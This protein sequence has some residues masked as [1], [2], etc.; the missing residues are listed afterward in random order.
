MTITKTSRY[1]LNLIK[2]PIITDKTSKYIED[3]RYCFCVDRKANK[4]LIKEAIEYMFDVKVQK[5]NTLIQ[6]TKKKRI[7]K[8]Q[9]YKARYKKAIIKL[10][11]G[12]QINLFNDN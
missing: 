3:N 4:I 6:P 10:Y 1:I 12:Y 2:Y 7:G 11:D 9:G 8:F 5:I